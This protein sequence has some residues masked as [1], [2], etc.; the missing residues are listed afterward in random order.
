MA[1][2]EDDVVTLDLAHSNLDCQNGVI[3]ALTDM[4]VYDE[5]KIGRIMRGK[6]IRMDFTIFTPE[7]RNNDVISNKDYY[8]PQGYCKNFKFEESSTIFAKYI[9]SNMAQF[10]PWGLSRNLGHVRCVHYRGAGAG[11]KL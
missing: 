1:E 7:L 6:R 2:E 4:L 10:L 3:H 9:G 5:D 8:V 11:R